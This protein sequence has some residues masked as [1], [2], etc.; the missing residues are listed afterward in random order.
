MADRND[1][2]ST[3]GAIEP[4]KALALKELV[5]YSA[6]AIVSRAI[7][8]TEHTTVTA[9]AFDAGQALSEHSAPFDAYVLGLDGEAEVTIAGEPVTSSP[10]TV[11]RMPADVPHGLRATTKFKMLLIMARG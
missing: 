4:A 9:F 2:K 5:A 3:P 7:V 10:G 8:D 6:G 11:I 1:G